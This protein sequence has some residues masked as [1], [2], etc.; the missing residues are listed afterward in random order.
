MA[1]EPNQIAV[2]QPTAEQTYSQSQAA[3]RDHRGGV[4]DPSGHGLEDPAISQALKDHNDK[5]KGNIDDADTSLSKG[6]GA[7]N[8][9]DDT[10]KRSAE[11]TSRATEPGGLSA[12]RDAL[13]RPAASSNPFANSTPMMPAPAPA[14]MP[15]PPPPMPAMA[16]QM[17]MAAP[18]MFNVA[19][20]A[21]AKL[22]AGAEGSESL[23]GSPSAARAP[24]GREPLRNNEIVT[25]PTG[26]TLTRPQVMAVIERSLDNNGVSTNPEVRARWREI[27]LNQWWKESSYVPDAVNRKDSNAQI[28]G[29]PRSD[30]A[31]A[32]AT[33]GIAQM[34]PSTFASYHVAGTSRNMFDPVASGSAGVAY[35]MSEYKVGADGT[36]LEQFHARRVAAGYGGY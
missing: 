3:L 24:G 22:L 11:R 6:K 20:A 10:D 14:A 9:L 36:G 18:G 29:P 1:P 15:A 32:E 25:E 30:G 12:L 31:P 23:S 13:S 27:L 4:P 7:A 33:R 35:M 34:K 17:P 16:P 8:A 26:M 21:L 19:P 5:T 28:P 2:D